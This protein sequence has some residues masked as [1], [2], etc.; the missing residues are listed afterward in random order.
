[1]CHASLSCP[2]LSTL[3]VLSSVLL[4]LF[5]DALLY[6]LLHY[7]TPSM[8]SP[9]PKPGYVYMSRQLLWAAVVDFVQFCASSLDWRGVTG[10]LGLLQSRVAKAL[11]RRRRQTAPL[12]RHALTMTLWT[13]P[14]SPS[15][16][17]TYS[18]AVSLTLLTPF[19]TGSS[20]IVFVPFVVCVLCVYVS[21]FCR[22]L[23]MPTRVCRCLPPAVYPVPPRRHRVASVV[24]CPACR[25]VRRVDMSSATSASPL[26]MSAIALKTSSCTS[27]T[28]PVVVCVTV[29]SCG[30]VSS[31]VAVTPCVV[32]TTCFS[33]T[34]RVFR[35]HRVTL[36]SCA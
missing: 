1:V 7:Q 13:H 30:C 10:L 27:T 34:S 35:G 23:L 15:L 17:H 2:V 28:A 36:S 6:L 4:V 8:S 22:L 18:L 19:T 14:P 16:T 24:A 12:V 21:R 20:V 33:V 3:L 31:C 26:R 25:S 11:R 9:P 5:V 29:S 32:V